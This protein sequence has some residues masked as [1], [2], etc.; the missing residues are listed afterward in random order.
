MV[1]QWSNR[2]VSK[3]LCTAKRRACITPSHVDIASPTAPRAFSFIVL[4]NFQA[5][6][7]SLGECLI[8]GWFHRPSPERTMVTSE[9]GSALHTSDFRSAR[10]GISRQLRMKR[11]Q[12]HLLAAASCVLVL[13]VVLAQ[14]SL[15]FSPIWRR[16]VSGTA[17][18]TTRSLLASSD[19]AAG[20]SSLGTARALLT[21]RH[22]KSKC[23]FLENSTSRGTVR[24]GKKDHFNLLDR[25]IRRIDAVV[26]EDMEHLVRPLYWQPNQESTTQTLKL[27]FED[28]VEAGNITEEDVFT[29]LEPHVPVGVA[30][31][32]PDPTDPQLEAYAHFENNELCQQAR[33][34]DGEGFGPN[35]L[36][37]IVRYSVDQKWERVLLINERD[38]KLALP[39][40][41]SEDP[42]WLRDDMPEDDIEQPTKGDGVA[43]AAEPVAEAR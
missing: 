8:T 26:P 16:Y 37:V 3:P 18:D 11:R 2:V 31:F 15:A 10:A 23:Q 6:G 9:V 25:Y 29:F 12:P 32:Q 14:S 19:S 5:M 20:L 42:D 28:R 43:A 24:R 4:V 40:D 21:P 41:G 17:A 34:H 1:L 13:V 22:Y 27:T 36:H 30:L 35:G 33:R 38:G 7:R 39:E